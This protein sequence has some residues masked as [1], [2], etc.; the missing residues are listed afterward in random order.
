MEA[1]AVFNVH[2]DMGFSYCCDTELMHMEKK[3]LK[4][5]ER[6][7]GLEYNQQSTPVNPQQTKKMHWFLLESYFLLINILSS[8]GLAL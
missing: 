1:I 5:L 7:G 4:L 2:F 8:R 6:E 3:H